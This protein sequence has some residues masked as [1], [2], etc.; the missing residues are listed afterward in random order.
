M[1]AQQPSDLAEAR[2]VDRTG[3]ATE[4]ILSLALPFSS[5]QTLFK[6]CPPRW[7]SGKGAGNPGV[8]PRFGPESCM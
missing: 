7:P 1:F 4:T 6:L 5:E 3:F 8:E 2:V